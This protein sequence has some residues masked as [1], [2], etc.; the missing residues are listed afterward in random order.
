MTPL[1]ISILIH[2]HCSPTDFRDGDFS[3][4]AVRQAINE[5]KQTGFIKAA[6]P[7][8][9]VAA[10]YIG[11]DKCGVYVQALCAV[12]EPIQKWVVPAAPTGQA[13]GGG[14]HG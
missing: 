2:Y 12:P 14:D 3:A 1:E 13:H 9:N 10:A 11:T 7:S 8:D 6:E 5:F 4:P